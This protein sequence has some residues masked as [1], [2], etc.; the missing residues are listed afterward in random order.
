[1]SIE[2]E[3]DLNEEDSSERPL[4]KQIQGEDR[5]RKVLDERDFITPLQEVQDDSLEQVKGHKASESED[6]AE[7]EIELSLDGDE[8]PMDDDQINTAM[9]DALEA[10]DARTDEKPKQ[11]QAAADTPEENDNPVEENVDVDG[12]EDKEPAPSAEDGSDKL[13]EENPTAVDNVG[14][15]LETLPDTDLSEKGTESKEGLQTGESDENLENDFVTLDEDDL[16]PKPAGTNKSS[17]KAASPPKSNDSGPEKGAGKKAESKAPPL[18]SEPKAP[19][20]KPVGKPG[21]SSAA[22]RPSMINKA[23]GFFL[24]ALVIAAYVF[25]NNPSLIGLK[26]VSEPAATK[27]A[28][29]PVQPA[30][31]AA[32]QTLNTA[33]LP[34]QHENLMATIEEA[35]DL[36]NQLL[37]KREEIDKLNAYYSNGIA[38]LE[39]TIYQEAHKEGI[40]S[41]EQARKNK[42]IELSLRTIQRRRA[43]ILE[44]ENPTLWIDRG[45]EELLYLTRKAELDL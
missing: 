11:D 20:K 35:A 13:P 42:R 22:K 16:D 3:I 37:M 36:R 24:V 38:E 31:P 32:T 45:S 15:A 10:D 12:A 26:K 5:I 33:L 18:K 17:P 19:S 14:K 4:K 21:T 23:I 1:M 30:K 43:Y 41:F 25:Y 28:P 40:N 27:P 44:L 29:A 34:N 39:N 7:Q 2:Q 6:S 8:F 9:E